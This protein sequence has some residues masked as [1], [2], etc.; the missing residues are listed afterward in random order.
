ML[1]RCDKKI[2]KLEILHSSLTYKKIVEYVKLTRK[3]VKR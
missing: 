3:S 2:F 1:N